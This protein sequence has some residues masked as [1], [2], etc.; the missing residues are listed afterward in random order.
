MHGSLIRPVDQGQSVPKFSL[1][2]KKLD[3]FANTYFAV[4]QTK[5]WKKSARWVAKN[6]HVVPILSAQ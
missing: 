2:D 6:L 5:E 4:V 1:Q 3:A